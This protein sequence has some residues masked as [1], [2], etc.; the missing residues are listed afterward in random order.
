MYIVYV[1]CLEIERPSTSTVYDI[2]VVTR[3]AVRHFR[4]RLLHILFRFFGLRC[5]CINYLIL[6]CAMNVL[7]DSISKCHSSSPAI[8]VFPLTMYCPNCAYSHRLYLL[9]RRTFVNPMST[10]AVTMIS[11]IIHCL[12]AVCVYR[13]GGAWIVNAT[14]AIFVFFF[15]SP[16]K[17]WWHVRQIPNSQWIH[18]KIKRNEKK[19][20]RIKYE[21]KINCKL[22]MKNRRTEIKI[23]FRKKRTKKRDK[24][25]MEVKTQLRQ[26]VFLLCFCKHCNVGCVVCEWQTSNREQCWGKSVSLHCTIH[27]NKLN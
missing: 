21:R 16:Y 13:I 20:T 23:N 3:F 25:R 24:K 4:A 10:N 12:G 19:N 5:V 26:N 1:R 22:K 11:I 14:N 8:W 27:V 6:K 9:W 17:R 15:V 7:H 2:A 18:M